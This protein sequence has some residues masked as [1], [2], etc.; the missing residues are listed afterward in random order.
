MKKLKNFKMVGQD[1]NAFF[2]MGAF[3]NQAKREGWNREEIDKV[4]DKCKSGDYDNLLSTL[5]DHCE[6]P[7]GNDDGWEDE[8]FYGEQDYEEE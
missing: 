6:N 1:G 7:M 3:A 8:D 5:V 4:L 2:L